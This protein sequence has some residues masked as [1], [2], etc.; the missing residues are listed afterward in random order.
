MTDKLMVELE[1]GYYNIAF[2]YQTFKIDGQ[3]AMVR[4]FA[5]KG[6]RR[7]MFYTMR[8]SGRTYF[9]YM[10]NVEYVRHH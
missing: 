6:G 8:D 9:E 1:S 7:I 10:D 4:R 3:S 5:D 2:A